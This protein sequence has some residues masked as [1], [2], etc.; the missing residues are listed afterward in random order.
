[1]E[2]RERLAKLVCDATQ[3]TNYNCSYYSICEGF[4][5]YCLVIAEELLKNGVRV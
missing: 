4:C 2:G 5:A 1:M 3:K